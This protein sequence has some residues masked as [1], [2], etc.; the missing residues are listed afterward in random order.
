MLSLDI[1]N[2]HFF[3]LPNDIEPYPH[4]HMRL[5][6]ALSPYL[7]T[8]LSSD[9]IASAQKKWAQ[10]MKTLAE[11]LYK[12]GFENAQLSAELTLLELPNLMA[13]LDYTQQKGEAEEIVDIAWRIEGLLEF[14]GRSQILQQVV[15]TQQVGT[16]SFG[17]KKK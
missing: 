9:D 17:K 16:M 2:Y 5:H 1:K 11:F 3:F 6:P 8:Q 12:K 15:I 4:G 14:L 10:G 7:K 13:L